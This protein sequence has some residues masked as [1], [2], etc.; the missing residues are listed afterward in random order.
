HAAFVTDA[1]VLGLGLAEPAL[2]GL[3]KAGIAVTTFGPEA[4]LVLAAGYIVQVQ[5][6]AW[7]VR[8][9]DRVFGP[10]APTSRSAAD[11]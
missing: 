5:A 1:G 6:A 7:Y 10:A 9:T 11:G 2:Q 3:R 4:A 8:L